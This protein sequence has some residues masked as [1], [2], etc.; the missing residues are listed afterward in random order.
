MISSEQAERKRFELWFNNHYDMEAIT[1][2][3]DVEAA[4]E[5]WKA[6]LADFP[7]NAVGYVGLSNEGEPTRFRTGRFGGGHPV[8]LSPIS[9]A[10]STTDS[11]RSIPSRPSAEREAHQ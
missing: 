5:I 2:P 9:A 3:D 11:T 10:M 8:Y 4:W 7:A 6:A 1:G